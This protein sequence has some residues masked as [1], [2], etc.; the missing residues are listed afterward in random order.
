VAQ[1][2][3]Q[4]AHNIAGV[5]QSA[6]RTGDAA[7]SMLGAVELLDGE[8]ATLSDAVDGFLGRLRAGEHA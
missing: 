7:D 2:T 4:V 8:A 6:A 1:G 5:S 3:E